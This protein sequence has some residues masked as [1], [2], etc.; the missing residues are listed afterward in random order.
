MLVGPTGFE[1]QWGQLRQEII[2]SGAHGT[3]TG[4][5]RLVQPKAIFTF[6][7]FAALALP[8]TSFA[9]DA[10]PE[11]PKVSVSAAY[12]Q[13]I[14]ANAVFIARGEA[15]DKVNITARVSGFLQEVLVHDGAEVKQGDKL[16]QIEPDSYSATLES[17]QADLSRAEANLELAKIQ[18]DR[19]QQ[20]F[21]RDTGTESD[22]DIALANEKVAEADVKSAQSAITLA[23]LDLSYTEIKAPFD[24]RVGR[25]N[26]S[27]G[28]IVNPSSGPLVTLVREAPIYVTF[29][30]TEREFVN[31]LKRA[32]ADPEEARNEDNYPDVF[33]EL[34][35]GDRLD[36]IGKIVFVDNRID[37]T[38]GSISLRAKFEN[39][40]RLIVDGGFVN[41]SIEATEAVE[42][43]LIPMASVQRDQKGPFVLV[44]NQQQTVEQR[45]VTLGDQVETAVIVEDGM[46]EGE[47]VIVEGLQRVR[48]GV[49][50]NAVLAGQPEG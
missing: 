44:V 46:Q 8:A 21:E 23:E 17:R 50:V 25:V 47:A 27:I 31:V 43:L 38:T 14:K 28:D 42:K 15:V 4:L 13:E 36:E 40:S 34:Q 11:P 6:L 12:S 18:L 2:F 29:S 39:K 1:T 20:L 26:P 22:R 35:N 10:E 5:K 3:M 37:P 19:K 45:Y 24:G 49:P 33:V 9:Q 16:F 30:I 41:V 7:T 48:P 32:G